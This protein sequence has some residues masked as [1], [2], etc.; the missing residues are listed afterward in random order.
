MS[1]FMKKKNTMKITYY[2]R[3]DVG[4][5]ITRRVTSSISIFVYKDNKNSEK[6]YSVN[7]TWNRTNLNAA[8]CSI[9]SSY[10]FPALL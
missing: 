7:I 2:G 6:I 4:L 8:P 9:P 5:Q 3:R 1:R 10:L